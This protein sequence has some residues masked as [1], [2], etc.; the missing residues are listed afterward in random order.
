MISIVIHNF[1]LIL[2]FNLINLFI[3]ANLSKSREKIILSFF[4]YIYS[5]YISIIIKKYVHIIFLRFLKY[6]SI[7]SLLFNNYKYNWKQD[8]KFLSDFHKFVPE[9]INHKYMYIK[10]I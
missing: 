1:V 8:I 7:F 2:E 10:I 3:G 4:N 5:K 9:E 6:F